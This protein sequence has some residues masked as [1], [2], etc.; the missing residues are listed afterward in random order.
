MLSH[1]FGA[2]VGGVDSDDE[3]EWSTPSAQSDEV[4]SRQEFISRIDSRMRCWR[5]A[6]LL[7][8]TMY[9]VTIVVIVYVYLLN[10][11]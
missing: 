5:S 7:F 4:S 1:M 2:D 3:Y 6:A 10:S 9:V 11:Y 8:M